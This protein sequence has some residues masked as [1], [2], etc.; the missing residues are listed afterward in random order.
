MSSETALHH[1]CP[2]C[3]AENSFIPFNHRQYARCSKCLCVERNRL[4][5]L[6]LE[7]LQLPNA[8][9]R[10]LH[11]A[12]ELGI[13]SR[14]A[15]ICGDKYV[16]C[17]ISPERYTSKHYKV[18]QLDLCTG[19]VRFADES[20][21]LIVHNH[22]LE[23]LPCDVGNVLRE[24]DRILA[25]GGMHLFS[26]PVRGEATTEDISPDVSPE[27]RLKRF[28]Q[29]DH[30]RLFG[31][32]ELPALLRSIWGQDQVVFDFGKHVDRAALQAAAIPP[33]VLSTIDGNTIFHR[34]KPRK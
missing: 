24:L 28:G 22:V 32:T 20:F 11:F 1:R 12:P 7:Q 25:P 9:T 6:A 31:R 15:A 27:E 13:A 14:L 8:T 4:M 33:Q 23:H 34:H 2:I 5:W 17:D 26:V 10:V 29:D 30:M 21:D 16:A 19:L 18:H 3:K